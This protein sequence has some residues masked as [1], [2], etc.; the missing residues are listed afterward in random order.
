MTL[1]SDIQIRDPFV[2]A[3]AVSREYFLYGTSG[4]GEAKH[5]GFMV[6]SSRDLVN[7]SEPSFALAAADGPAGATYFWA[8]EVFHVRERWYLIGSFM[9]GTEL[10]RPEKRY[11]AIYAADSPRGPFHAHSNGAV[12]P[13][14]WL[15]ID[16]TLH[17]EPDGTPWLVFVREWVQVNDGEMH[18]VRLTPDL[19]RAVG[20]PRLLFA[21]SDAAWSLPQQWS[22]FA[23]YRVT[24]GPWL[25]RTTGGELLM[26]WSTFGRGGYVTG[27]ARS[28]SGRILGPWVQA[29]RTLFDGDGGHAML[30]RTFEAKWI[31]AL[32]APNRPGTERA[33]FLP[34][35]E[36]A[37]GLHRS[38]PAETA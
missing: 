6:R 33:R 30:F 13:D 7:W 38:S 19:R 25:H 18:A 24:D 11:T 36:R 23:G 35:E 3:D 9:H 14:G 34:M 31:M 26:L 2:V 16:G 1:L 10:T 29:D 15:S 20:A 32:H 12:T 4:F 17:L 37:E 21:A 27:I 8:P 5:G 22:T 28:A